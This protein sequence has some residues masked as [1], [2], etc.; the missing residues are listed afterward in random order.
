M[1]KSIFRKSLKKVSICLFLSWM[2]AGMGR[3]G[4]FALKLP[5]T[6]IEMTTE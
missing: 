4:D 3:L 1:K 5:G 2:N 6:S